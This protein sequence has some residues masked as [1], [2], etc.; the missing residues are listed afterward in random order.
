[1]CK[2]LRLATR[3]PRSNFRHQ[4]QFTTRAS[5][6]AAVAA[7]AAVAAAAYDAASVTTT[8][9]AAAA[10]RAG[11]DTAAD[12]IATSAISTAPW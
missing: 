7:V 6:R 1:M 11:A 10:G 5:T 2:L 12:A 3:S 9:R 8:T 4:V